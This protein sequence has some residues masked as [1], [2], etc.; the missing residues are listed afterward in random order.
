MGR[1]KNVIA[2]EAQTMEL[3]A[4]QKD[5]NLSAVKQIFSRLGILGVEYDLFLYIQTGKH[6][7]DLHG[8]TAIALGAVLLEIRER[9]KHGC[10]LNALEQIGIHVR[11]A[12]RYIHIAK[13]YAKLN[14][15][16]LS[17]LTPSKFD[18]IDML[19]D[20]ELEKLDAGESVKGLTLDIIDNLTATELRTILRT[21]EEKLENQKTR[22]TK[23]TDK[24]NAEVD[25]LKDFEKYGYELTKKEK[26]EKAIQGKLKDL[27]NELFLR[28]VWAREYF[29]QALETI[30]KA[31]Q[32]E[33][34]TFPMLETWAK[35]EYEELA[36]FNELF[37]ELD[38][39]L[40]YISVDKGNRDGDRS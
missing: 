31:Q 16:N 8:N 2:P 35:E 40:N 6:L 10:F 32:L 13:R 9:E 38:D 17:H 26:A 34:V 28:V 3:V 19:T 4:K 36:G 20:P 37:E 24:L 29:K 21:T 14:T 27:R 7:K 22:Y 23:E 15:T 39:A 1:R 11:K 25:R 5:E 33:G 18:V 30:E 12:Q